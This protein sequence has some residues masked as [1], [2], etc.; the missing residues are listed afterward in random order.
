MN[1]SQVGAVLQHVSC[2]TV[3]EGMRVDSFLDAG[4]SDPLV[5]RSRDASRNDRVWPF[6]AR[7][8]HFCYNFHPTE[9]R[10]EYRSRAGCHE[11]GGWRS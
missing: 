10:H 3:P 7:Q 6:S 8:L 5:D 11:F 1:H 2:R 9:D 4:Q